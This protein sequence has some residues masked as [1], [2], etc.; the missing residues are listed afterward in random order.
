MTV[1]FCNHCEEPVLDFEEARTINNIPRGIH[2]ECLIR[3]VSG[4]VGHQ[5]GQCECHG[6]TDTSEEGMTR[7]EAAKA[8][9]EE[10]KQRN[11]PAEQWA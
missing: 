9:Y 10:W 4:S 2:L 3:G 6:I 1:R 7:R 5:R 8:A 11:P